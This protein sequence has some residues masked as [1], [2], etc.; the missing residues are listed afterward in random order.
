MANN[1]STVT[2]VITG[3]VRLSYVHAFTPTSMGDDP[4][5]R[6]KYS[7]SLIIPKSDIKTLT[8]INAAIAAA[9]EQGKSTKFGGTI[10]K[11][12]KLPL[13]D[14]DD[15]RDD[16]AYEN[17]YFINA[18]GYTKPE[19]IGPDK[20]EIIDP[21]ELYSGCYAKVS[22]NFYAYNAQ[23]N[24]GIAAGLNNIMKVADGEM[25]GGK[26]SAETDFEDEDAEE[27]PDEDF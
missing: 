11:G 9:K 14:G 17:A 22:I 6:K 18:S 1:Q 4:A 23:G 16:E 12:L 5:A 10:P 20:Q 19:I 13:R 24:K 21:E 15:E 7:V 27:Y 26:V 8:K 25:L 2:K 3:K